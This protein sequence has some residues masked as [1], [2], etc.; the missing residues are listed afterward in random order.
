MNL[1][2]ITH[3]YTGVLLLLVLVFFM[4]RRVFVFDY[5]DVGF[6]PS[7]KVFP[8]VLASMG[9]NN[10]VIDMFYDEQDPGRGS[11]DVKEREL[12]DG[13]AEGR[14]ARGEIQGSEEAKKLGNYEL[15]TDATSEDSWLD[16]SG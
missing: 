10:S 16:D 5:S 2:H 4:C 8:G 12:K 15:E 14:L 1:K 13:E 7:S 6:V 11:E 9:F 3:T